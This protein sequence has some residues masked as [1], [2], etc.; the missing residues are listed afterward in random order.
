[1]RC[2]SLTDEQQQHLLNVASNAIE[3]GLGLV[4]THPAKRFD[5]VLRRPRASFVTLYTHGDLRGCIG[6]LLAVRPLDEDVAANARAAAFEDPRFPP[7]SAQEL[8]ELTLTL[9]LLTDPQP[10]SFASETDLL[11]QLRPGVDGLILSAAGR[12][13]TFLPA[14]W[15]TLPEPRDFLR[16][17]KRKAGLPADYWG[18]DVRLERYGAESVGP[19]RPWATAIDA[20]QPSREGSR[21]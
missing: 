11:N 7:V 6:T 13:G 10:M 4:P 19:A 16:Q 21:R 14:V 9:S 17:L 8:P 3:T 18:D 20:D 2:T 12:R 5:D 1:M 15:D